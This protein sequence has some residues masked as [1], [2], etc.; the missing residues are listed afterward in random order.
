MNVQKLHHLS[1]KRNAP[2]LTREKC[3]PTTFSPPLLAPCITWFHARASRP[4]Y[5]IHDFNCSDNLFAQTSFNVFDKSRASGGVHMDECSMPTPRLLIFRLAMQKESFAF[6]TLIS[7]AWHE[8]FHF[9]AFH[10]EREKFSFSQK[11]SLRGSTRQ[12]TKSS[13]TVH[14]RLKWTNTEKTQRENIN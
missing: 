8:V 10:D 14:L 5:L 2:E 11:S 13:R 4:S 3:L 1:S 9:Q 7:L 12:S 6:S